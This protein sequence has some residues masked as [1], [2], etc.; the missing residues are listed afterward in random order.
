MAEIDWRHLALYTLVFYIPLAPFA[1]KF[2]RDERNG[3]LAA[4]AR[5]GLLYVL[6]FLWVVG[7]A[8]VV[9][10]LGMV[11][12]RIDQ[13]CGIGCIEPGSGHWQGPNFGLLLFGL[14]FIL[15]AWWLGRAMEWM[16]GWLSD[17]AA[18]DPKRIAEGQEEMERLFRRMSEPLKIQEL[19]PLPYVPPKCQKKKVD[20]EG[21]DTTKEE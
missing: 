2:A 8:F 5:A 7:G 6:V 21:G 18:K 19:T 17:A 10:G 15:A 3:R 20:Q 11:F 4:I 9:Y 13:S 14:G 1:Y 12:D 16:Q